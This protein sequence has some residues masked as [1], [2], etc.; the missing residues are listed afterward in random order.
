MTQ[1]QP[2]VDLH[3]LDL[4]LQPSSHGHKWGTRF[5]F[6]LDFG[7]AQAGNVNPE[8]KVM[9][10]QIDIPHKSNAPRGLPTAQAWA[11]MRDRLIRLSE[12]CET[13]AGGL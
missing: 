1:P 10:I 11:Q 4:I 6:Q 8:Q 3:E 12:Q 7:S 13:R 2:Q 9:L 5:V